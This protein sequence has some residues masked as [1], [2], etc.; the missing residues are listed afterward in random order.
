LPS[1]WKQAPNGRV[2]TPFEPLTPPCTNGG[3][4]S[5][6]VKGG[7]LTNGAPLKPAKP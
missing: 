1:M 6:P 2:E 3:G 5:H 7:S 4:V